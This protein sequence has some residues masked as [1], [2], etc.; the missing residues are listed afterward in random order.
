MFRPTS[1][2][3]D[4]YGRTPSIQGLWQ[5]AGRGRW[6]G[7]HAALHS[8]F[9]ILH[10]TLCLWR[11]FLCHLLLSLTALAAPSFTA[12]LDRNVIAVGDSAALT[13]TFQG[14]E[15]DGPPAP[16][17]VPNLSIEYRGQSSQIQIINGRYSSS[18][19]YT[20]VVT[21]SQAGQYTIPAITAVVDG[22]RLTSQPL[23]LTASKGGDGG[24]APIAF[25]TLTL[26]KAEV[27]VG[28]AV[29]VDMNLFAQSGN[30]RQPPQ[31]HGEGVTI[32]TNVPVGQT[33]QVRTNN[34]V[35]SK[36]TY[37]A[38]ITFAKAGTLQIQA[39]DCILDVQLRRQ[40]GRRDPF[41]F[42]LDF[43]G[44]YE[45]R[46]LTLNTEPLDVR[47]LPLPGTN[48][49]PH[50]NGA[51]GDF[52]ITAT[53][54]TNVVTAGD[55]LVLT[56]RVAGHG[57]IESLSLP[58]PVAWE[59]FKTYAPATRVE[60]TDPFGFAGTKVFEQV[61]IPE[62]A[63]VR[64]IPSVS[65]SFFDPAQRQYR[66]LN[67]PA[68]PITVRPS[69]AGTASIPLISTAPSSPAAP[70]PGSEIVHIKSRS[71]VLATTTAPF[72]ARPTFLWLQTIP[73]LAWIVAWTWRRRVDSLA[74][75]PR[76]QRHRQVQRRIRQGLSELRQHAAA[77]QSH[78]F[79]ATVF[80]LLQEQIG[81][82]LDLPASAI[83]E[84]AVETGLRPAQ[85]SP[86]LLNTLHELFAAVDQARFAP[87]P[88][89]GE[90]SSFIPR[91]EAALAALQA[92][93]LSKRPGRPTPPKT[94]CVLCVG[95]CLWLSLPSLLSAADTLA[96][97]NAQFEEA[98]QL[99]EQGHYTNAVAAYEAIL[100]RGLSSPAIHFNLAN[101]HLRSGHLGRA[102]F[103][104]RLAEQLAPRD[105]DVRANLQF[106]RRKVY[107]TAG[108]TPR[109]WQRWIKTLSTNEWTVLTCASLW[110]VCSLLA[111]GNL[112]PAWQKALRLPVR[113]CCLWTAAA[114]LALALHW[115]VTRSSSIAIVVQAEAAVRY[116]PYDDSK[117]L[118]TVRDGTELPVLDQ[119]GPWIQITDSAQRV[120]WIPRSAVVLFPDA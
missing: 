21:P 12:T 39:G 14:G 85:V 58:S 88:S 94:L 61:I 20:Y 2:I 44:N 57:P 96:N 108:V 71:G 37:R 103:H 22:K 11:T 64:A 24:A 54:N 77:R 10:S 114:A 78:E 62:S 104:Y 51:V 116:G 9:S 79:H 118:V 110:V 32:G 101:A 18:L 81:E 91:V 31:L 112:L 25:L 5:G 92:T 43:F 8:A 107:G 55:T 13:L 82:L 73:V 115:H 93:D 98:N 109:W 60:V 67:T 111:L 65:F 6:P 87:Q 46:R 35:Y 45:T 100:Q 23:Q 63:D 89:V 29:L 56:V 33:V 15:P 68:I 106:A 113:L 119:K 86:E 117:T 74:R 41:G 76:L 52:S 120:G 19:V 4:A 7:P 69:A 30:L 26:P 36:L 49:P 42:D 27:Y 99:Y 83:T 50:F 40:G 80:R 47:V 48:V 72:L 97:P 90:L 105:P 84:E 59:K 38:P 16:P 17:S 95:L 102:I 3:G 75:N 34:A 1:S 66:T 70:P 53:A 28:E